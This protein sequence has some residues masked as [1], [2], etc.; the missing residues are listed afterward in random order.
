MPDNLLE[1]LEYIDGEWE[2][3]IEFPILGIFYWSLMP[4]N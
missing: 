2:G 4:M 3:E 1:S